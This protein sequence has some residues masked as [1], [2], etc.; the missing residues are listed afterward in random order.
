MNI[1]YLENL[2]D[3][4]RCIT[5]NGVGCGD[6]GNSGIEAEAIAHGVR[7]RASQPSPAHGDTIMASAYP[8][9]IVVPHQRDAYILDGVHERQDNEIL[10][11]MGREACDGVDDCHASYVCRSRKDVDDQKLLYWRRMSGGSPRH[12]AIRIASLIEDR[13][14][15]EA[16]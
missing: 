9:T 8:F 13:L 2:T 7:R 1:D 4:D 5:C 11:Q 3:S 16:S 12:Q 15:P 10:Q 6:C 14:T